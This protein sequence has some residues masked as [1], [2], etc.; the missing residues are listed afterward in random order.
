MARTNRNRSIVGARPE[1]PYSFSA[2][3]FAAVAEYRAKAFSVAVKAA[4]EERSAA[5]AAELVAKTRALEEAIRPG[6][7]PT[8]STTPKES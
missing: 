7:V 6:D 2:R 5:R 8:G 1:A 3:L 4:V